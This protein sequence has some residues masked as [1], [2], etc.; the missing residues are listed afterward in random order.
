MGTESVLQMLRAGPGAPF[1]DDP[2]LA[3]SVAAAVLSA[4]ECAQACIACADACLAERR[5]EP[6]RRCVR[7]DLDCADICEATGRVLLRP[8]APELEVLR[9]LLDAT[10]LACRACAEECSQYAARHQHCRLCGE[11][12]L[13]CGEACTRLREAVDRLP[14]GAL[15]RH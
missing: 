15:T 4:A 2:V 13:R 12:C 3:E 8:H 10:V 1:S 7:L 9:R 11:A 14:P 5:I 6:L